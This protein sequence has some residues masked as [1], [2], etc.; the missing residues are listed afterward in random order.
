MWV[1]V[2]EHMH[3]HIHVVQ[4]RISQPLLTAPLCLQHVL[5]SGL[6]SGVSRTPRVCSS[7]WTCVAAC[8]NTLQC[9]AVY[10]T[11]LRC[12][13]VVLVVY[14]ECRDSC[15]A[16]RT[17][18]SLV[19]NK[20]FDVSWLETRHLGCMDMCIGYIV[21]TRYIHLSIVIEGVWICVMSI[22]VRY[23]YTSISYRVY[24]YVW[25]VYMWYIYT[26]VHRHLGR[27]YM[28]DGQMYI[29]KSYIYIW[30]TD[31]YTTCI[32]TTVRSRQYKLIY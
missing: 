31:K 24:G 9:V 26:S 20:Q 3:I 10:C 19:A 15:A 7:A 13:A 23:M 30:C 27:I 8:C 14:Q 2:C 18:F 29:S 32:W 6:Y 4:H 1:C 28:C 17:P 22:C 16:K 12:V 21:Y 11:V 25:W 5:Q